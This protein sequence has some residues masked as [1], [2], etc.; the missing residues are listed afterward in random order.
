MNTQLDNLIN[1]EASIKM[2]IGLELQRFHENASIWYWTHSRQLDTGHHQSWFSAS[3]RDAGAF[4]LQW[5][6]THFSCILLH[7]FRIVPIKCKFCVF[8]LENLD[9]LISISVSLYIQRTAAYFDTSI[10]IHIQRLNCV[11]CCKYVSFVV[12]LNFFSFRLFCCSHVI[13]CHISN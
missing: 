7:Y 4:F 8:F 2:Q 13:R 6:V 1:I 9:S 12:V 10:E 5:N 11:V 3:N